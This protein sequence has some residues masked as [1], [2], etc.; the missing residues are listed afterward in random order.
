[1]RADFGEYLIFADESGDHGLATIDP[2]FP[3][4][5]LA[6]CLIRKTD[7]ISK[8]VP[9]IQQLKLD[10]WG[11]DQIILRE[12]DIR[13]EVGPFALLRTDK[14][15]RQE[16]MTRL[17]LLIEEA[18]IH[19][20][21][22]VIH[23]MTLKQKY[24]SPHNPYDIALLFCME[25][26]LDVLVQQKQ[27]RPVT[28]ILAESRGEKEDKQLMQEFDRIRN[29]HVKLDN[30]APNFN[31]VRFELIFVEKKSNS[32]GLQLA[33]LVARPIALSVLRPDQHNRAFD[34]IREKKPII[35]IFP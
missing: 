26:S 12:H 4:F 19:I 8:I 21:A 6:F 27:D 24:S 17:S 33:D 16:F 25:R 13:K 9:A 14:K 15:L 31:R 11:H 3:V 5:T 28:H 32:S 30:Q 29:N 34:S 18:P 22:S 1:M 20:V 35:K 23:K 2:E 10:F 7:Y